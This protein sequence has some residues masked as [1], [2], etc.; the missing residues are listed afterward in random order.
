MALCPSVA[1]NT[2]AL[3]ANRNPRTGCPNDLYWPLWIL[4]QRLLAPEVSGRLMLWQPVTISVAVSWRKCHILATDSSL[5]RG[6]AKPRAWSTDHLNKASICSWPSKALSSAVVVAHCHMP[7]QK[8]RKDFSPVSKMKE[9]ISGHCSR[10]ALLCL[11]PQLH[12]GSQT[13]PSPL[14]QGQHLWGWVSPSPFLLGS[15]HAAMVQSALIAQGIF[16]HVFINA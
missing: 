16:E 1:L 2:L 11:Q 7:G 12:I 10:K 13:R 4:S 3:K 8:W 6:S 14:G 9:R 5:E 15:T